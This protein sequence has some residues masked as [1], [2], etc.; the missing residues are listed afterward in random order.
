MESSEPILVFTR[1]RDYDVADALGFWCLEMGISEFEWTSLVGFQDHHY[2]ILQ[3][4]N[5]GK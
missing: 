3:G 5:T 2:D 1:V 4:G